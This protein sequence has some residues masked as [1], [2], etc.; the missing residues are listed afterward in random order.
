MQARGDE[1]LSSKGFGQYE[2]SAYALHG[3][4]CLHNLNYWEFGDYL[5]IGAGAHSKLTDV[6]TGFINRYARHRLPAQY[7]RGAGN[8]NTIVQDRK[9]TD[10]DLIL[11]FMMNAMRLTD[12]V[13]VRLFR[14][15]TGL[16]LDDVLPEL[17]LAE[18]RGL[19]ARDSNTL[20]STAMGRRYLNDLLQLFM[21]D[22]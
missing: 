9:L 14:A 19:V 18:Q 20:A 2:I 11:E 10:R 8:R 17:Q 12:G 1:L 22:P 4:R 6:A 3:S 5:G 21:M 7:I 15:R 16:S 13:Q